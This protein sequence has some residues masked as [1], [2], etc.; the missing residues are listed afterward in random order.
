VQFA[1]SADGITW[2]RYNRP[3]YIAP[4]FAGSERASMVFIGPGMVVRGDEI[5]QYG[6]G[7]R[8]R[9]GD[10]EAR[11]RQPDGV[12]YR[13]VQRL[14]GFVSAD[15][16]HSG[17]R[18]VTGP[19]VLRGRRLMANLDTG[20]LGELRVGLCNSERSPIPGYTI[21]ES[22]TIRTNSTGFQVAWEKTTR[23]DGIEGRTVRIELVGSRSKVYS[24]F[25]EG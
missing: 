24:L 23:I 19:V 4:D 8:H 7:L 3:P 13:C 15:F 1:G 5:W 25:D 22:K 16:S 18:L 20:A 2:H 21:R 14:D 10:Q 12:V 11:K 17:G 6:V 9:H